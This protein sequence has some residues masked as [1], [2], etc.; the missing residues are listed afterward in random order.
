[1]S[2]EIR[3]EGQ[4]H[5][6]MC[7]ELVRKDRQ[8]TKHKCSQ[9]EGLKCVYFNARSIR[10]KGDELRAWISTWNYD[11]VAVT[12]TWLEE[13]QDWLM[14]VPGFRCFKRNR[15]GGRKGGE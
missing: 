15:M 12:E 11:V 8:G 7:S 3:V 4:G 2:A 10:N 14:Q 5:D 1:M 13:G 6:A 9:L